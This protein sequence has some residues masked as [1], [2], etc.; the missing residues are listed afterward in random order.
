MWEL[1]TN[2]EFLS[3]ARHDKFQF[4][5]QKQ[6]NAITWSSTGPLGILHKELEAKLQVSWTTV[7]PS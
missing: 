6:G 7:S 4:N 5:I 1:E 3:T 2:V